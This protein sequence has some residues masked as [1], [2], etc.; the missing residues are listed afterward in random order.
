MLPGAALAAPVDLSHLTDHRGVEVF[1]SQHG[2]NSC[3][4]CV[5]RYNEYD[6]I[7]P[8]TRTAILMIKEERPICGGGLCCL[9]HC[10]FRL[11]VDNSTGQAQYHIYRRCTY[12]N[13][14]FL[15]AYCNN[16]LDVRRTDKGQRVGSVATANRCCCC[17]YPNFIVRAHNKVAYEIRRD[18]KH[19]DCSC[20]YVCCGD[21]GKG[22]LI[23]DQGGTGGNIAITPEGF[24]VNFPEKADEDTRLLIVAAT[25]LVD[26]EQ[27]D[28]PP[29]PQKMKPE[30]VRAKSEP[31]SPTS[32]SGMPHAPRANSDGGALYV[33][34][35]ELNS[36][37]PQRAL[38][39]PGFRS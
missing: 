31:N 38:S 35:K 21:V 23:S 4:T 25:V 37:A 32:Q 8:M 15:C 28:K 20:C 36:P 34:T 19:P 7:S 6:V 3:C 39:S 11:R 24:V 30:V 14:C 5:P 18:V 13:W 26:Y 9:C 1:K 29:K 27:Y 10:G 22:Y 12:C 17:G 16:R 33:Q 2:G